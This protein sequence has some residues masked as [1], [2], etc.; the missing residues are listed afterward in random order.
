M[1]TG[2]E[3]RQCLRTNRKLWIVGEGEI[4]DVTTHPATQPMVD[5]YAQWY[6]RH[7]DLDWADILLTEPDRGGAR[8]P[9]AFEIPE[10]AD[11]LRR[12]GKAISKVS[13]ESAGNVTH[14]PGYGALI[15]LG[16]LDGVRTMNV[17]ARQIEQ[18]EDYRNRL[19]ETGRFL[20]FSNG[21][22][23]VGVR[24]RD[25][26]GERVAVRVVQQRD[27][28]VVV[29]GKLGLHTAVPY[30][31]DVYVGG[32]IRLPDG[33]PVQLIV[34]LDAAGVRIVARK[35]A[36]RY[37]HSFLSPLSSR[38]DELDAQLWLNDVFVPAERVF[39]IDPETAPGGG[40]GNGVVAWV[41]WHQQIGWLA[42][43]EYIL[44]V[45]LAVADSLGATLQPPVVEQLLDLVAA[46]QTIRTC[47]TAA[48]L[49]PDRTAGGYLVPGLLHLASAA[50]Y[51]LQVRQRMAEILRNIGGG[52]MVG[53]PADT[54]LADHRVAAG[55]EDAFG[56]GGY[57]ALQRSA[58][59]HLAGDL[60]SSA[61]DGR[62]SSFELLANG[63][64]PLWRNRLRA[65]FD[66]Y[67]ELANGVTSMLAMQMPRVD[68]RELKAVPNMSR[69]GPARRKP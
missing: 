44:G 45:A 3:Y 10:S 21:G 34:E 40:R 22:M 35:R 64:V 49:D 65:W 6:D 41:W 31:D 67:E 43:A 23:P 62:E 66:G 59:L 16:S 14:T 4:A 30:A 48:E 51:T 17:S 18:A 39:L 33:T 20:T 46:V 54:D 9:R 68:L 2:A 29:T 58:L 7:S 47:V 8:K 28:G 12:L 5:Y 11:D 1:R 19:A 24:L 37:A 15:A 36:A 38:F 50:L 56:G 26:P 32:E 27:G 42:R 13:F 52:A 60:V 69:P 25:D 61:L 63:G 57:T 53:A 55:F